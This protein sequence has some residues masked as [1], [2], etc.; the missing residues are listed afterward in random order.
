MSSCDGSLC[1]IPPHP[2]GDHPCGCEMY[3]PR[4]QQPGPTVE[5]YC[6]AGGHAYAGDEPGAP[7]GQEARC[8]CGAVRGPAGGLA[9]G[10]GERGED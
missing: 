7:A 5:D 1:G 3:A 6:A 2:L 8:Y 4:E 9:D 10:D